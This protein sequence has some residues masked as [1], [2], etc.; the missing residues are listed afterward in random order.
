MQKIVAF[1]FSM[2][3]NTIRIT[4]DHGKPC[5]SP[6]AGRSPNPITRTCGSLLIVI[7][8]LLEYTRILYLATPA[9]PLN[10]RD[11]SDVSDAI[12]GI[13]NANALKPFF[14]R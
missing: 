2:S 9:C 11:D 7:R 14:R 4:G 1:Y 10:L 8:S 6:W 13:I 12:K 5:P 3:Y